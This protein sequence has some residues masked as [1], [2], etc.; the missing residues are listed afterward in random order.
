MIIICLRYDAH[1]ENENENEN[2]S[3]SIIYT[4]IV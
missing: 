4:S 3:K 1:M 2:T